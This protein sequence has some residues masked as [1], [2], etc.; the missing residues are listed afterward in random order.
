M[1]AEKNL[2]VLGL[3]CP[4]AAILP[5]TQFTAEIVW[6][7]L[8][9]TPQLLAIHWSPHPKHPKVGLWTPDKCF[10]SGMKD[11]THNST[12]STGSCSQK[13]EHLLLTGREGSSALLHLHW[14]AQWADSGNLTTSKEKYILQDLFLCAWV[15]VHKKGQANGDVKGVQWSGS[16]P[17]YQLSVVWTYTPSTGTIWHLS[18]TDRMQ[19]Q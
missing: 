9:H 19:L 6:V 17:S 4:T 1:L 8:V 12:A 13:G 11:S 16:W 2:P 5:P 14:E 3:N 7:S 15:P 10:A 18:T